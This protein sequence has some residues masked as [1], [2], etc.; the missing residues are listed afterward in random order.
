[1]PTPS[2]APTP[3]EIVIVAEIMMVTPDVAT[4]AIESDSTQNVSDAKWALTLDDVGKW[5]NI[6]NESGDVKKVGSI[7]FFEN[8][9]FSTRLD[10]RNNLRA[11]YGL[12]LL[13]SEYDSANNNIVSTLRWC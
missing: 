3:G 4:Q 5:D 13:R 11:R 6:K 8:K 2:P 10:F 12:Y 9:N 1:M 7:E